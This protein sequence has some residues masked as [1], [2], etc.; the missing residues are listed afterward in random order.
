MEFTEMLDELKSTTSK[1]L[2]EEIL[3]DYLTD[4]VDGEFLQLLLKETFDPNILHHVKL[5]KSD[6]PEEGVET[7]KEVEGEVRKMFRRLHNCYSSQQNKSTV[8]LVMYRLDR[9]NQ[10]ALL[11]VVNKK[12]RCGVS[13]STINAAIPDLIE[14]I[15]IQLANKYDPEKNYNGEL[16]WVYVSDKLDGQR[17]FCLRGVDNGWKKFSRGGDYLGNEINTLDHWDEELERYY[18]KEGNNFLDGEAYLHGL[19]FEQISSLVSSSVNRKDATSLQYHIFFAGRTTDLMESSKNNEISGIPPESIAG[20]LQG[21]TYL[22][23]VRQEKIM[24]EEEN[25]FDAID[26]AVAEG[27]EGVILRSAS[28]FYDFKRSNYLLKAKKSDLSGTEEYAD[29]YVEDLEYGDFVVREDGMESIENLPVALWV[30]RPDDPTTQTM[31]VGS[32]FTLENRRKWK[33]DEEL[34]VGQTIEVMFQ[35]YGARGRMRFPRYLRT[36]TDI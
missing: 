13:I 16:R 20:Q 33:E 12:L 9:E 27:Y 28:K 7:L 15:K 26:K 6:L 22:V 30:V 21:Y 14:V 17:I 4:S 3:R 2:K 23:G 35:G 32:G 29:V 24:L 31:K 8:G 11:G 10:E 36:R 25:V 19:T 18:Q 1:T 5:K 34:I